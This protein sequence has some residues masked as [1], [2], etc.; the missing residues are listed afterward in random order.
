MIGRQLDAMLLTYNLASI[1]H[2]PT[3]SQGSSSTAIDNIFIDTNQFLNYTVFPLA[4][5]DA[6]LLKIND[7]N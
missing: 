2:F 4:D 7:L 3:R 1:A 5:H 6:Q